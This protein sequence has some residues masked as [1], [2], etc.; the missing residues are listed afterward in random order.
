MVFSSSMARIAS[1]ALRFRSWRGE[2]SE[3]FTSCWVIVEPPWA[4]PP[5]L[6]FSNRARKVA[7]RLNPLCW[8]KSSSSTARIV[9]R[10][11]RGMRR[12]RTS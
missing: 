5:A 2:S 11:V 8:K 4:M 12:S 6:T 3:S 9:R 10:T 1:R 7:R